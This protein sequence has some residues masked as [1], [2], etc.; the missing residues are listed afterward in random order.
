M[1]SANKLLEDGRSTSRCIRAISV[2]RVCEAGE[3]LVAVDVEGN[4]F[5]HNMVRIMV[6]T[7]VEVGR[8]NRPVEWVAR[9]LEACDRRVAGPTAPACGLVFERVTYAPGALQAWE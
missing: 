9:A 6:G 5:L 8:G 1:S 7:L 3:D 2:Q 4:A